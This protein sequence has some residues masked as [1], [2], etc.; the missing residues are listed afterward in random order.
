MR[1][2]FA[3]L[4][5]GDVRHR[6]QG[7]KELADRALSQVRDDEFDLALDSGSN[8]IAHLVK[9]LAGNLH[10]RWR[11]PFQADGESERDRDGEFKARVGDS[12]T[13]LV[14]RWEAGWNGLFTTLQALTPDD[15][16]RTIQ[17]RGRPYS[18][19]QA[20]DRQLTHYAVHVGQIVFL[21]KHYRSEDWQ[22]LSIPRRRPTKEE[23]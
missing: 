1:E 10:A 2:S 16:L 22:S 9:H 5:L 7:L 11:A 20:L 13:A 14:Q 19:M 4:Y 3:T 21:S 12:R 8:S 17:V 6:F 23:S 18:V 15:L